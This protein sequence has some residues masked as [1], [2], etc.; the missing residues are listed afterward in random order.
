MSAEAWF[1]VVLVIAEIGLLAFTR[2][3]PDIIM[4]GGLTLLLI[5]GILTPEE[6][7][8]GLANEGMV[9]VGVLYLVVAGLRDTGGVG[10]IVRSLLGRPASVAGAQFRLMA[11]VI[12]MSAFLNNTPVVAMLIPAVSDWARRYRL[13]PSKLM[14]PLS[15]AAILGGTC[16]LIGT[17]TNLVVQGLLL[18]HGHP[19]MSMFEIGWVG[20]PCAL[21]G[22]IYLMTV[23]RVLLPD[24]L[25]A[26]SQFS[27]P[28]QY[29]VEMMVTPN[30]PLIGQ[31]IERAGLRQLPGMF[32]IELDRDGSIFPAVEPTETLHAGDRLVFA[33][34]VESVL[35]LQKIRGLEPAT[36]Q[37]FKLD[38]PRRE[39][40]LIEAVVSNSCPMV[41][42]SV[43]EGRFRSAYSAVVIAVAR[44]GERVKKKIGDIILRA[45]D[46]LLL[47]AHRTFADQ[48]RNSRD[49]LLVSPLEGS[50]P[51]RHDRAPIALAILA[52]MVL[53][54]A[55]EWL[56]M[57]KAA[58]LAA[59]LMILSRSVSGRE[60]R[61]SVD[62]S[63]LIVIAASIALGTALEKTGAAGSIAY[64][65][66]SAAS[67]HPWVTLVVIYGVTMLFTELITNNAAAVLVFPIA[68]ATSEKLGVDF[69]P[70]AVA[71]MMAASA[72]FSTPIGYQT[73]LMV[74]GPGGY[75]FTDY[76][77]VGIPLNLLMWAITVAIV[78]WIWPFHP[79]R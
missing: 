5:S 20:V 37:V 43:R 10:W 53:V 23:G 62:W 9:T 30:S 32:L 78:P 63:V 57:L 39:R 33:G 52:A 29:T 55:F 65:L 54:V 59:G 3:A 7:L 49:F 68:M 56:S 31:T 71:I 45:G 66:I 72:S 19:G 69:A 74:Y 28:R 21:A 77:R 26:A 61:K 44:D 16:T 76:F 58:M 38:A 2:F 47:E 14:I 73:N 60:A 11:P 17:S 12:A 25:P 1:T 22:V 13:S 24:R 46:T 50:A 34:V 75:K 4:M 36:D 8:S 15:Y 18:K 35:D 6:S 42:R 70:F 41:G 48:H 64:A 51:P 67:S 79:V 40:C 27:D